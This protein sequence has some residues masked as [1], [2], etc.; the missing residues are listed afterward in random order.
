MKTGDTIKSGPLAGYKILDKYTWTDAV[1]D[2][3][4]IDV[5]KTA[6]QAGFKVPAAVTREV[7]YGYLTP[8][9]RSA[10]SGQNIEG[11]LWDVLSMAHFYAR[12]NTH[13]SSFT[14]PVSFAAGR[15]RTQTVRLKAAVGA[16][17]EM[18]PCLTILTAWEE[19]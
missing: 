7:Y 18:K 14:F 17:D 19:K 9:A 3:S 2:G 5:S 4:L 12:R 11:R 6:K 15:D 13:K 10:Q 1:A 8:D 16:D